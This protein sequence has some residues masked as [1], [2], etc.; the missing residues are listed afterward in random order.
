MKKVIVLTIMLLFGIGSSFSRN[1]K[2]SVTDPTL[3]Q[4][5]VQNI[6]KK[7]PHKFSLKQDLVV[8]VEITLNDDNEI[9]VLDMNCVDDQMKG[10][11]RTTLNY[12]KIKGELDKEF[13]KSVVPLRFQKAV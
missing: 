2:T 5:E 8:L 4:S 10:Y 6:I 3:V 9:V 12:R 13:P 11:I 7:H 1:A